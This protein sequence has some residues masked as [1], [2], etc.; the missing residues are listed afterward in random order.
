MIFVEFQKKIEPEKQKSV[1]NFS[2]Y[3]NCFRPIE[4]QISHLFGPN[5]IWDNNNNAKIHY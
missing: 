4:G 3:P 2:I 1:M 5:K